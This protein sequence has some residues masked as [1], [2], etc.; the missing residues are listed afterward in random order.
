MNLR[1]VV[2]PIAVAAALLA[3]I[4]ANAQGPQSNPADRAG[5]SVTAVDIAKHTITVQGWNQTTQTIKVGSSTEYSVAVLGTVADLK[6]GDKIRVMGQPSEDDD[7]TI[8]A[9]AIMLVPPGGGMFGGGG[10]RAGGGAPGGPGG[11]AGGGGRRRG[12]TMGTIATITPTITVTT[13]D[14]ETKTIDTTDDTRVMI[15]KP[16]NFGDIA[17]GKMVMAMLSDGKATHVQ[18]MPAMRFGGFG[19]RG[20]GQGGPGGGGGGGNNN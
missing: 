4:A 10:H 2:M 11:G 3:P 12:G 19:R 13:A 6:V 15:S 8:D 20:G 7:N 5:G 18:I 9:R 17:V 14:N 16:G 1:N